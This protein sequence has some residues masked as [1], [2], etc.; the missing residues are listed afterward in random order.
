MGYMNGI[1]F[2]FP[3]QGSQYVG[4]GKDIVDKYPE[5]KRTFTRAKE[6]LGTDY[7]D[8]CLNGPEEKLNDT[9]NTQLCVYILS[10]GIY[11]VIDSY[12]FKPQIMAGHSLGEYSA[13]TAS[14][15]FKFSDGLRI[16][17]KRAEI[18]SKEAKRY[19]GKMLAVLG[20]DL[21]AVENVI[22]ELSGQGTIAIANYNCPGQIVVSIEAYMME[23]VTRAL[24]EAGAKKIIELP[25]S[26]A[27]HSQMMA[28]A[29]EQFKKFLDNHIFLTSEV[30]IV[31]N[32]IARPVVDAIELRG[33]LQSQ[34]SSSVKWQQSIEQMIGLGIRTFVEIGPGDVL[35][36]IIKRIDRQADIMPTDKPD[37]LEAVIEYLKDV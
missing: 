30:P 27:F 8:I 11:R 37:I 13:L 9:I 19:P 18:M 3:G 20:G 5:I 16:V 24:K 14:Q 6:I 26:G 23:P 36:K 2:V 34:I 17:A 32:T 15:T 7:L 12:G 33:A 10:I 21:R 35:S 25:V 29:E 31:P 28:G 4:M 22:E 1:A